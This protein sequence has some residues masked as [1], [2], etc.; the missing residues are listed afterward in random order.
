MGER[1]LIAE[2]SM[3]FATCY[4]GCEE[5]LARYDRW[6]AYYIRNKEKLGNPRI[7]LIDDGSDLR[8]LVK[9]HLPI[10]EPSVEAIGD[11]VFVVHFS[12]NLGRPFLS[13]IPGWWRSFS[14]AGLLGVLFGLDRLIHIESDTYV[15]SDALFERLATAKRW[16]SP[17]F[18]RMK[19]SFPYLCV[20]TTIQ[21]IPRYQDGVYR[22]GFELIDDN[23][24]KLLWLYHNKRFWYSLEKKEDY[25]PEYLLP[26]RF[27]VDVWTEFKGG[28]YGEDWH[29]GEIPLDVD[30]VANIG[31]VSQAE[32]YTTY[33]IKIEK[34]FENLNL[35]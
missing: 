9:L 16:G 25:I 6:L 11:E 18:D 24:G 14:Y 23:F 29:Q 19:S 32:K 21:S 2:K 3:L 12:D 20:E 31:A 22:E 8:L 17:F 4:V 27:G 35:K 33:G 34:F 5:H 10:Y 7:C 26:S 30:Y 13:L 15:L 28:R 1:K